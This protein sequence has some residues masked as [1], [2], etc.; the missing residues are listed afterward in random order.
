MKVW[1]YNVSRSIYVICS[2]VICGEDTEWLCQTSLHDVFIWGLPQL[3]LLPGQCFRYSPFDMKT[4]MPQAMP[5]YSITLFLIS[6]G[7]CHV[8]DDVALSNEVTSA[9]SGCLALVEK[10]HIMPKV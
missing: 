8:Q 9:I 4:L 1:L 10:L 6:H 7:L 2:R 3:Y 5:F